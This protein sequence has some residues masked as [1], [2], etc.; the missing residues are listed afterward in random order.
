MGNG[1]WEQWSRWHR[2][3]VDS[4]IGKMVVL[5]SKAKGQEPANTSRWQSLGKGKVVSKE[6]RDDGSG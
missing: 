2:G 4:D 3:K 1:G 5:S 6:T